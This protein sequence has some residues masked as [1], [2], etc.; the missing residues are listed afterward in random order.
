MKTF[1]L[2]CVLLLVSLTRENNLN[3]GSL[4]LAADENDCSKY[5]ACDSN[6]KSAGHFFCPYGKLFDY[7]LQKCDIAWHVVCKRNFFIFFNFTLFLF[8]N[9]KF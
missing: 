3:C 5:Y 6:Q 9:Y 2:L 8:L 7:N 4:N 1:F